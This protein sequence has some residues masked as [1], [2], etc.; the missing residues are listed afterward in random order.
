MA[1]Q[2][3]AL[4]PK[5]QDIIFI[6]PWTWCPAQRGKAALQRH[7]AGCGRSMRSYVPAPDLTLIVAPRHLL[8]TPLPTM[9]VVLCHACQAP[10]PHHNERSRRLGRNGKPSKAL[11]EAKQTIR[12]VSTAAGPA[13]GGTGERVAAC[14][15]NG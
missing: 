4:R 6:P 15:S 5:T 14:D 2:G 7:V 8:L 10:P 12:F 1:S 11:G 9:A 3:T 13:A